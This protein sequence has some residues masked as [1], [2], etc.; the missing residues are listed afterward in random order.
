L[1]IDSRLFYDDLAKELG[2]S[3]PAV[4]KR[5]KGLVESGVVQA[6]TAGVDIAALGGTSAMVYGH[7][8]L[9]SVHEA[10]E[11]LRADGRTWLILVSGGGMMHCMAFLRKGEA[12]D[13]YIEAVRR[14]LSMQDA[15]GHQHRLRPGGRRLDTTG[16]TAPT[17]LE[18]RILRAMNEDSRRRAS[19]MAGELG[20]SAR[21]INNKL[22]SMRKEGKA[23][24]SIRWSADYSKEAVALVHL[25]LG[26]AGKIQEAVPILFN[27]F[28]K[29]LVILSAFQDRPDLLVCTVW[30]ESMRDI[31]T[32]AQRMMSETGAEGYAAHPIFEAQHL[33]CWKD[34]FLSTGVDQ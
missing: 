18:I 7:S 24:F 31:G 23:V 1:I 6:F 33:E 19:E 3:I 26:E 11:R 12:L 5:L 34:R 29:E 16:P 8:S 27:R 10:A 21:T 32:I 20:V 13:D 9:A 15:Q 17:P 25:R 30:G 2:M 28:Q 4:H 22:L 14:S